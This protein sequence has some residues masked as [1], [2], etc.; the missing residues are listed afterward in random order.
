MAPSERIGA[1]GSALFAAAAV[2]AAIVQA[3]VFPVWPVV[4]CGMIVIAAAI[5]AWRP[6][7]VL[8]ILPVAM[9]LLDLAPWSGR[10]LW[11]EFDLLQLAV[12]PPAWSRTHGREVSPPLALSTRVVFGVLALSLAVSLLRG[13]WPWPLP[14]ASAW[15]GVPGPL[16]AARVGKGALWAAVFVAVMRRL[17]GSQ[18]QRLSLAAVGLLIGLAGTVGVIV[19]ERA[20]FAGLLDFEADYRVTGPFSAMHTGGATVECFLA[21]GFAVAL[22]ALV[23]CRR[24]ACRTGLIVLIVL[25]VYAVMVTYSRNGW[26]AILAAALVIGAAAARRRGKSIKGWLVAAATVLAAVGV[27]LPVLLGGFAQQRLARIA[28]DAQVRADHWRDA[29]AMRDTD[30]LTTLFGAGLG[31]FPALHRQRSAEAKHAGTFEVLK[32]ASA[33]AF[34][35]LGPG[36]Q[37]YVEQRVDVHAG[38]RLELAASVRAAA[39]GALGVA[40]CEKWMLTSAQCALVSPA[41]I[42]PGHGGWQRN[43]WLLDTTRWAAGPPG[44]ARPVTLALFHADRGTVDVT[45]VQLADDRPL[46]VNGEFGSGFDRWFYSTDVDPPWHI[47]SLPIAILFEQGWLGALAWTAAAL[48]ALDGSARGARRGEP[49]AIGALAAL[50][51][52]AVAGSVN[53]LFDTP[54]MLWLGCLLLWGCALAPA[55]PAEI[56]RALGLRS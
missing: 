15:G 44:P 42:S 35:R 21:V 54:R 50:A 52:L 49:A 3:A 8:V 4:V 14:D 39:G 56:A 1:V 30:M 41:S 25:T 13:G 31:R 24:W 18:T 48:A 29:L 36:T 28:A 27:A 34:L 16:D 53:S 47:H 51:A 6:A 9:P 5:A 22:A 37:I 19:W 10:L 46:I 38:Q 33:G 55:R 2:T 23:R 7:A 11:D 40:L 12:L 20:A 17:P 32:D 26:F 43:R 45:G